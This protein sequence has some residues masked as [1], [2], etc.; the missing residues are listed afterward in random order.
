MTTTE[1]SFASTP[2]KSA[3]PPSQS[4][5]AAGSARPM[6]ISAVFSAPKR[7]RICL[8]PIAPTNGGRISGTSSSAE[9]SALPRKS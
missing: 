6:E 2:R 3:A 9:N 7:P 8:S 5:G 1:S 4:G